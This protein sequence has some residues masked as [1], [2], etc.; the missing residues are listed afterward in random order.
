[1][2]VTQ[3]DYLM[4][5]DI[6]S[7]NNRIMGLVSWEKNNSSR[8][9]EIICKA[10]FPLSRKMSKSVAE[11]GNFLSLRHGSQS[12]VGY[13]NI[14]VQQFPM[15]AI[16][17]KAYSLQHLRHSVTLYGTLRHSVTPCDTMRHPAT[18]CD[19]METMLYLAAMH[20][21]KLFRSNAVF[22]L[23]LNITTMI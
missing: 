23:I 18:P 16:C 3:Q 15:V 9:K 2:T 17:C 7:L 11:V 22:L 4:C 21:L 19:L 14:S 12:V 1:M 6:E 8:I 13:R 5:K 10:W 20:H